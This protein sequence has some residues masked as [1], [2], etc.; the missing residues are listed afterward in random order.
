MMTIRTS[1]ALTL[2]AMAISTVACGGG[3]ASNSE[4]AGEG[5][6]I[7]ARSDDLIACKKVTNGSGKIHVFEIARAS[8]EES[9]RWQK[10]LVAVGMS[11]ELN[12]QT[13]GYS[14]GGQPDIGKYDK[15][16][17]KHALAFFEKPCQD[18]SCNNTMTTGDAATFIRLESLTIDDDK[19]TL[20]IEG[21][22]E[23]F[24]I[25]GANKPWSADFTEC[26]VNKDRLSL[27][28]SALD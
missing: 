21:E 19:K 8:R 13:I 18:L 3:T 6:D 28:R 22:E 10:R 16:G 11:G 7:R 2:L 24:G 25:G 12:D 26:D 17:A 27:V 9:D 14:Q 20:H 4:T 15:D 23:L 5:Q 1:I